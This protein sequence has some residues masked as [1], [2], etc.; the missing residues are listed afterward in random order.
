MPLAP[1]VASVVAVFVSVLALYFSWRAHE[2]SKSTRLQDLRISTRK[3]VEEALAMMAA[4]P[5]ALIDLKQQTVFHFARTG[6]ANSDYAEQEHSARG[7]LEVEVQRLQAAAE[8]LDCDLNK[9]SAKELELTLLDAQR[10]SRD[11]ATVPN[12]MAAKVEGFR[13]ADQRA[14]ERRR[15]FR[16]IVKALPRSPFGRGT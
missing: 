11:A 2:L 1:D 16:E 7:K 12:G 8:A 3:E 5:D 9:K 13:M 4:L 14:E 10:L 15:D 6:M